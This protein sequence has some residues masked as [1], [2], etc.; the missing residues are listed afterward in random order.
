MMGK[1]IEKQIL[2]GPYDNDQNQ[3]NILP[4]RIYT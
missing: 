3:Q 2:F 4:P 1:S